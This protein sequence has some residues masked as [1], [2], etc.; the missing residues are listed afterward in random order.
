MTRLRR[1][2]RSDRFT[3][4][5]LVLST[6]LGVVCNQISFDLLD[7]PAV[8]HAVVGLGFVVL[9]AACAIVAV[10]S[11]AAP[12]PTPDPAG[13]SGTGTT[14]TGVGTE[15]TGTSTVTSVAAPPQPSVTPASRRRRAPGLSLILAGMTVV[16]SIA[17]VIWP[18]VVKHQL[19]SGPAVTLSISREKPNPASAGPD[20]KEVV[21][22]GGTVRRLPDP[23]YTYWLFQSLHY[24]GASADTDEFYPKAKLVEV[25]K[26]RVD[27]PYTSTSPKENG[28]K[29]YVVQLPNDQAGEL[30][31]LVLRSLAYQ[32]EPC[33][34]CTVSAVVPLTLS[35]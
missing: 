30:D 10:Y 8:K 12:P 31:G 18:V 26:Y 9:L 16:G 29:V 19:Q 14:G 15:T 20:V 27:L 3:V 28:R 11:E 17:L 5:G 33:D 23:G 32:M 13:T 6:A 2:N 35:R 7:V 4:I 34:D 1:L 25:G 22:V 24:T 21:R